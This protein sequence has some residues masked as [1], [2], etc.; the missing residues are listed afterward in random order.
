MSET[1]DPLIQECST[2]G[3]LIDISD[4]E[5]LALMHCPTCGAAM[6]V[7]RLFGNFEPVEVLGA[8][9]MGAVYRAVDVSLNRSVALKLLRREYSDHPEV[10]RQFE[11]EALITAHVNHP[12]VVKVYSTGSDHGVFYIA[13][14]LVDRGSLDDLMTSYGKVSEVQVL[15]VG[16]QIAHGLNAAL[17]AG[18]IHRDIKPGNILFAQPNVAKIVDFGLAASIDETN[19]IGGEVWGTPYY[20]APE[21]LEQP[22]QE[23]FRS[24][25]YSLGATLFHAIAG[26]PPHD[27]KDASMAALRKLKSHPVTLQSVA[28]E[29]SGKTATVINRMINND[30]E[31]RPKSYEEVIG[32][33]EAAKTQFL[34]ARMK[35]RA[36][37]TRSRVIMEDRSQQRAMSIVTL[38]ALLAIAGGGVFLYKERARIF[39]QTGT[40]TTGGGH[41]RPA[42]KEKPRYENARQLLVQSK[43]LE[44]AAAFRQLEADTKLQQ[45]LLNWTTFHAGLS[46]LLGGN[47]DAAKEDFAKL[48]QRPPISEDPDDKKLS[49]FFKKVS[50]FVGEEAAT[51]RDAA[52]DYKKDTYE[53][54]LPL[55]LAAKDWELGEFDDA[56]DF[57]AQFEFTGPEPP[58][59]WIADYKAVAANYETQYSSYKGF[60][61]LTGKLT[62]P[63]KAKPEL[64]KLKEMLASLHLQ[65]ALAKKGRSTLRRLEQEVADFDAEANKEMAEMESSD[66]KTLA[67]AEEK[68]K[69]LVDQFK[70]DEAREGVT[71][72]EVITPKGK[73]KKAGVINK[74]DWLASFKSTL[75]AD[76][77]VSAYPGGVGRR[78]GVKIAGS[79]HD[80]SDEGVVVKTGTLDTKVPWAD[81]A[82]DTLVAMAQSYCKADLPPDRLGD[83]YWIIGVFAATQGKPEDATKFFGMAIKKKPSYKDELAV[84]PEVPAPSA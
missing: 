24:D 18:L 70:F 41:P 11:H 12:N 45:P 61:D 82:Y 46:N 73:K 37:T 47:L 9:G 4:E 35:P 58:D 7:R 23:D 1:T 21:K 69:P 52:K 77:A 43:P 10:T 16:V 29:V 14:E 74:Y 75:S 38:I 44:A 84:F 72:T 32:L 26:K 22:S 15:E 55:V 17:K 8:G 36:R 56:L 50:N 83:R 53:A 79:V 33:L 40:E 5:P 62:N 25:I 31:L 67:E 65:G 49:D 63:E 13:M 80:A 6:R 19:E 27:A 66:D 30:P 59:D 60:A 57:F 54:L 68:V 34:A 3:G 81:I 28:P 71:G 39:Q 42:L 2:C 51:P 78:V 48:A 64:P 76:L 20:V